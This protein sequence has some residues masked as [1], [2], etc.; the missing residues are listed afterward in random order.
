VR[1]IRIRRGRPRLLLLLATVA[2]VALVLAPSAGGAAPSAPSDGAATA[3]A[4]N[5]DLAQ[6]TALAVTGHPVPQQLCDKLTKKFK[7]VLPRFFAHHCGTDRVFPKV[8]PPGTCAKLLKIF[9][10]HLPKALASRCASP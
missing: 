5:T 4:T 6:A 1:K 3:T 8:L 7:G 2:G 10:G 9:D